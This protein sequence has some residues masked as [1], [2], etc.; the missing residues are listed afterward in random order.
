MNYAPFYTTLLHVVK[1]DGWKVRHCRISGDCFGELEVLTKTIRIDK[2]IPISHR[3]TVLAHEYFGHADQYKE[4][5]WLEEHKHIKISKARRERIKRYK[6]YLNYDN[7]SPYS[8]SLMDVIQFCEIDA[9]R[10][11][12]NELIRMFPALKDS[13]DK[14]ILA[15]DELGD[16]EGLKLAREIWRELLFKD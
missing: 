15:F 2:D 6:W 5:L 1:R 3:L 11:A 8:R 7:R 4:V 13:L 16:R 10:R 9:S 12:R 14:G